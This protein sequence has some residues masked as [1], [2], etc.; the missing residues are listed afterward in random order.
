MKKNFIVFYLLPF[1]IP[2]QRSV[3]RKRDQTNKDGDARPHRLSLEEVRSS[4]I[5][6]VQVS[7]RFMSRYYFFCKFIIRVNKII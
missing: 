1:L 6:K 3:K 2:P 4:F 5:L 7:T